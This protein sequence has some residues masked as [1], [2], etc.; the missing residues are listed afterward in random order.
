MRASNQR[1]Y[2][3]N[4]REFN[5]GCGVGKRTRKSGLIRYD[6]VAPK[7]HNVIA[8]TVYTYRRPLV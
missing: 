2:C 4:W 7:S 8:V 6:V 5:D 1:T 3:L